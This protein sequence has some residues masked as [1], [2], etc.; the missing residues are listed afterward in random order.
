MQR[1]KTLN[2]T[3]SAVSVRF[4]VLSWWQ[5][6]LQVKEGKVGFDWFLDS[7]D[8]DEVICDL[9]IFRFCSLLPDVYLLCLTEAAV[10]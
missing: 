1:A 8:L 3:Q 5:G 9:C 10:K 6:G 7:L 2:L 4:S